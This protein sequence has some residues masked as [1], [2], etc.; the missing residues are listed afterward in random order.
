[1]S[2]VYVVAVD[3]A[4]DSDQHSYN[5]GVY[6]TR[7]LAEKVFNDYV[8][9]IKKTTNYD[10]IDQEKDTFEAYDEGWYS[11]SHYRISIEAFNVEGEKNEDDMS[12]VIEDVMLVDD[13]TATGGKANAS[14]TLAQFIADVNVD[15]FNGNDTTTLN[16]INKNLVECGIEPI[17]L[18]QIVVKKVEA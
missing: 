2:K 13:A 9:D 12:I 17:T 10:T 1:M 16:E 7:E 11:E 8:E 4:Y 15:T 6:A 14:E 5:V 3:E 18:D